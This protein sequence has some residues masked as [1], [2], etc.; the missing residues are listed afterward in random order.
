MNTDTHTSG[1]TVKNHISLK[2]VFVFS[3]IRRTS[4]RSWFLVY[5]RVLP[6]ACLLQHPGHL[7]LC[8][9]KVR[10]DKNGETRMGEI[11]IP[12]SSQ[13]KV[14]KGKTGETRALLK[15][16]MSC[17]LS[18]PKSQNKKKTKTTRKNGATRCVPTYRNG[19]KNSERILWMTEFLTAETHTR[20]LL[21]NYL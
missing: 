14:S 19:C 2:T 9:A 17:S 6:Q 15:S 1:S 20:V 10:I 21:M 8:Q 3:A 12:Q 18:Q 4:F 7:Q 11:T 13:V 16:Q 5:Q